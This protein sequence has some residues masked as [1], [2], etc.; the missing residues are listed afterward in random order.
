MLPSRTY[1]LAIAAYFSK[2]AMLGHGK[3]GGKGKATFHV[4]CIN[5]QARLGLGTC[6]G[7]ILCPSNAVW[8][9]SLLQRG[10]MPMRLRYQ[11]IALETY[12][13]HSI[14]PLIS[15]LANCLHFPLPQFPIY[16]MERAT[17]P[18]FPWENIKYIW[19]IRN[20]VAIFL[21][22]DSCICVSLHMQYVYRIGRNIHLPMG[23]LSFFRREIRRERERERLSVVVPE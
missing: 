15:S 23:S 19:T 18:S 10:T 11:P 7:Y 14:L 21:K 8:N 6:K 3:M 13:Q 22:T 16:K 5:Y 17:F 20:C 2:V 12:I 4:I 9:I 1:L